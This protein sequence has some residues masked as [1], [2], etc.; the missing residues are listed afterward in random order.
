[1]MNRFLDKHRLLSEE[2]YAV[3]SDPRNGFKG[4]L[5]FTYDQYWIDESIDK[6]TNY[7]DDKFF[8]IISI[9]HIVCKHELIDDYFF[10]NLFSITNACINNSDLFFSP[11]EEEEMLKVLEG[12]NGQ[13]QKTKEVQLAYKCIT[14]R[15]N[16]DAASGAP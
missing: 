4:G 8:S 13:L 7:S 5:A 1:M 11:Q 16:R 2:F 6:H 9:L 10:K 15:S 3:S 14:I 12:L